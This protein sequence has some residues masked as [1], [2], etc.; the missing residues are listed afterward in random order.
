MGL[1]KL[2]LTILGHF[3]IYISLESPWSPDFKY[4][5][6]KIRSQQHVPTRTNF[7]LAS[8]LVGTLKSQQRISSLSQCCCAHSCC[9]PHTAISIHPYNWTAIFW[10]NRFF[11]ISQ[12]VLKLEGWNF[13]MLWNIQI[14]KRSP[15]P[16]AEVRSSPVLFGYTGC[17]AGS[18]HA[19]THLFTLQQ[20]VIKWK[21][22][23]N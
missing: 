20:P 3:T 9:T 18:I 4:V 5:P 2:N 16:V 17:H 11:A 12:K 14:S 19:N 15:G 7:W 21:F 23:L 10:G 13:D 8:N 22:V 1:K 6:L